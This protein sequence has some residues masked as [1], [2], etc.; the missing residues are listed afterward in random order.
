MA[1]DGTAPENYCAIGDTEPDWCAHCRARDAVKAGQEPP[2]ESFI[3]PPNASIGWPSKPSSQSS[4]GPDGLPPGTK[5]TWIWYD[6]QG[7]GHLA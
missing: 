2:D 3:P 4:S 7:R 1:K 5:P 6:D